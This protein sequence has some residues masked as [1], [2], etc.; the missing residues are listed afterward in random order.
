MT[1]AIS[2]LVVTGIAGALFCGSEVRGQTNVAQNWID[3]WNSTDPENWWGHSR[4]IPLQV[5]QVHE[6]FWT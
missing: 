5:R 3:G 4:R 2:V 1:K 6:M